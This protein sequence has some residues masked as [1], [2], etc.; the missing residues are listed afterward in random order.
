[1]DRTGQPSDRNA[2]RT[3]RC[4]FL[5]SPPVLS[6]GRTFLWRT[7]STN[8]C[9]SEGVPQTCKA[10]CPGTAEDPGDRSYRA[11][12]RPYSVGDSQRDVLK[13]LG[14]EVESQSVSEHCLPRRTERPQPFG[15]L[16]PR[17]SCDLGG[18]G[19]EQQHKRGGVH[20]GD[21]CSYVVTE[22]GYEVSTIFRSSRP[23]I[24]TLL[25]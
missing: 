7:S 20:L 8:H 3:C 14:Q 15:G 23:T 19:Q 1:M 4:R 12:P 2:S 5:R 24:A 25:L 21:V 16:Q 13:A 10:L 11:N 17:G 18:E 9:S 22:D 6:P